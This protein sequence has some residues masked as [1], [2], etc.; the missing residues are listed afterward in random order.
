MTDKL[1]QIND[2]QIE[3]G[4]PNDP[5]STMILAHAPRGNSIVIDGAT[6]GGLKKQSGIK[7]NGCRDSLENRKSNQ[8]GD[9]IASFSW[10]GYDNN[11]HV[12]SASLGV[13]VDNNKNV[14]IDTVPGKIVLMTY[15]SHGLEGHHN[16]LT[17]DSLGQLA[18]NKFNAT[19]TVDIEGFLKLKPLSEEPNKSKG[20]I[21]V[22][23]G[24]NWDPCNKQ[25]N[26]PAYYNGSEWVPM[27]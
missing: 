17:W 25:T 11:K 27:I 15:P 16:Y 22:A 18:V 24:E 8:P 1:K 5:E 6:D 23:D 7:F 4:A 9:L 12:G 3:L 20:A 19:A 2:F 10:N 13:I 21:A 14:G 26:Y